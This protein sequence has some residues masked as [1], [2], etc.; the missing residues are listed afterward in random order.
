MKM[1]LTM[2]EHSFGVSQK[3]GKAYSMASLSAHFQAS[4]FKK[5]GY[6]REVRGYEQAPVEVA[7]SAIPKLK[8]M[9]YPCLADVVTGSRLT[10]EGGKNIV[11]LVVEN[12]TSWAA[13]V[14]Q[15]AK[16]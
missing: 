16:Q 7:E 11:V 9:T 1:L 4:D 15:P 14:P 6:T 12:V 8:E 3:S 5:E 10:R 2:F 13:L